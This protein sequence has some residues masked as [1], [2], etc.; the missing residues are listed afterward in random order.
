MILTAT[1]GSLKHEDVNKAVKFI[2]LQGKCTTTANRMKD[3]YAAETEDAEG[4]Y[5]TEEEDENEVFHVV[6]DQFQQQEGQNYEDEEVLDVLETYQDI[7]K[8]LQQKKMGRGYKAQPTSWSLSGT[9]QGRLEQLKKRTKCHLCKMPGHWKR[10]CP[11]RKELGGQ[12]VKQAGTKEAMIGSG[13]PGGAEWFIPVEQI[14]QLDVFLVEGDSGNVDIFVASP[15][16]TDCE[17]VDAVL[18]GPEKGLLSPEVFEYASDAAR[19]SEA[20]MAACDESVEYAPLSTHAAVRRGTP[21]EAVQSELNEVHAMAMRPMETEA[22]VVTTAE[23][24]PWRSDMKATPLMKDLMEALTPELLQPENPGALP[25][26]LL[27]SREDHEDDEPGVPINGSEIL[28]IGKYAKAGQMKTFGEIYQEEKN[29]I[30][31]I[32]KFVTTSKPNA[33]G[34]SS[35]GPMM[36]L[37]L[38]VACRDQ[39]KEARLKLDKQLSK[40]E[41]V[42]EHPYIDPKRTGPGPLKLTAKAKSGPAAA[43]QMVKTPNKQASGSSDG[44]ESWEAVEA[45]QDMRNYNLKAVKEKIMNQMHVLQAQMEQLEQQRHWSTTSSRRAGS[46]QELQRINVSRFWRL[47]P[48]LWSGNA[49]FTSADP[50]ADPAAGPS[51]ASAGAADPPAEPNSF[52]AANGSKEAAASTLPEVP[53]LSEGGNPKYS[54]LLSYDNH[55]GH[56]YDEWYSWWET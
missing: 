55:M 11:K 1:H 21:V 6:A 26:K 30:Q 36:R 35:S 53:D 33:K 13:D 20:Y 56:T 44:Y 17:Q 45:T 38:Y 49:S 5:N 50:S 9:V 29:Y 16:E 41:F 8:K 7:R 22:E 54:H 31:W 37:R 12:S 27:D 52:T 23:G 32:R 18:G 2:F 46:A 47:W 42:H 48:L 15:G 39:L 10:E 25:V 28:E 43:K 24:V 34:Q 3:V 40:T 4:S 51:F 19:S 14:E